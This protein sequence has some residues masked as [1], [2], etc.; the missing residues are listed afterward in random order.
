MHGSP[1]AGV[2]A[3]RQARLWGIV[4]KFAKL[5]SARWSHQGGR[6]WGN[7]IVANGRSRIGLAGGIDCDVLDIFALSPRKLAN[8]VSKWDGVT[9]ANPDEWC[10]ACI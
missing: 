8:G 6:Y 4:V 9:L 5:G 2:S 1:L 7:A 10:A 3:G